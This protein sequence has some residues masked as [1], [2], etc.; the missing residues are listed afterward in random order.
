MDYNKLTPIVEKAQSGDRDAMDELLTAVYED[1]YFH[2]RKAVNDE[3]LA[4]DITQDV[5][6]EVIK[7]LKTLRVPNLFPVWVKR[8]LHNKCAS[9]FRGEKDLLLSAD[10]DNETL[11][12]VLPDDNEANIPE[13]VIEDKE[14][15]STLYAIVESLPDEQKEATILYFYEH[16]SVRQIATIQGV[17]EETVKSRLRYSRNALKTKVEE[18]ERRTGTKLHGAM[19]LP[20]LMQLLFRQ[21]LASMAIPSVS[22][23]VSAVTAATATTATATTAT[24][25]TATTAT[26]TTATTATATATTATAT[27]ATAA[28]ATA[29][30]G[31]GAGIAAKIVAGIVAAGVVI[32]GAVGVTSLIRNGNDD[33]SGESSKEHSVIPS[34]YV[35]TRDTTRVEGV[36]RFVEDQWI[37]DAIAAE[38]DKTQAYD[39]TFNSDGSI[40]VQEKSYACIGEPVYYSVYDYGIGYEY[41]DDYNG[42]GENIEICG[43]KIDELFF[44][45]GDDGKYKAELRIDLGENRV[46]T[47]D[48]YRVS[49]YNDDGSARD[50]D[51]NGVHIHT[52]DSE[53]KF[54]ENEHWREC[55]CGAFSYKGEHFDE[56]NKLDF[57][58]CVNCGY[59]NEEKLT[60]EYESLTP[61]EGL[62]I[63]VGENYCTV[64]GFGSCTDSVIVIPATYEGKPVTSIGSGAFRKYNR[65]G[66]TEPYHEFE[67]IHFPPTLT[68]IGDRAFW[69]AD[70]LKRIRIYSNNEI[71]VNEYAF[72][73]CTSLESIDSSVF[74]LGYKYLFSDCAAMT[75][76]VIPEGTEYVGKGLLNECVS[77]E[78]LYIPSS[79]K[80]IPVSMCYGCVNL[81]DVYYSGTMEEWGSIVQSQSDA[82]ASIEKEY[83]W[84]EGSGEFIV[85][86][87]DGDYAK[88]DAVAG[89]EN[90]SL[91]EWNDRI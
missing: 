4:Y 48:Y 28:T 49:D 62:E 18:Y 75:E 26:A 1:L 70:S 33:E 40:T 69:G 73:E 19:A 22:E 9:H 8:I 71:N 30:T 42:I 21:E 64:E 60:A 27:T 14:F 44:V 68:Y 52:Y 46:A 15:K 20:L 11:L 83:L 37:N 17:G 16:M 78:A 67:E 23:A 38:F 50:T 25:T 58:T 43:V 3:H 81:T 24:A 56:V 57:D 6:M 88:A 86:C 85:H 2:A 12:D 53:Y 91:D 45:L 35:V 65:F 63:S 87:T 89:Y 59:K 47:L 7:K 32:G 54:D 5:C 82:Y 13:K 80:A 10:E 41:Y 90:L 39:F 66:D 72:W 34:T 31:I 61:S 77:L 51:E 36:W 74:G 76:F 84:Y 29:A 55:D 79:M